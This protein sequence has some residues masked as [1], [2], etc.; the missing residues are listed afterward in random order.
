MR[1]NP[2]IPCLSLELLRNLALART[3][4]L[5]FLVVTGFL[6]FRFGHELTLAFAVKVSA[7]V[8]LLRVLGHPDHFDVIWQSLME[9][10]DK[11]PG[12]NR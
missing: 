8:I 4:S 5:G 3:I 2:F 10:H 6:R 12:R 7:L 1:T 9:R 11:S